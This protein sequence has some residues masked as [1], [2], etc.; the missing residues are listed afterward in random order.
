[1][2]AAGHAGAAR[3]VRRAVAVQEATWKRTRRVYR[4]WTPEPG[5]HLLIDYGTVTQGPNRGLKLFTAVLPW[6]RW[7]F[8]RF[9]RDESL[10][11]T[12]R[13]LAECFEALGGVPAGLAADP[14][15]SPKGG[16]GANPGRPGAGR[17]RSTPH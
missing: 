13:L 9:T 5:G 1:L 7:R 11:T 6:S 14:G 16:G 12:L 2:R 8:V 10:E 15:G 4:P 3:T 17:V